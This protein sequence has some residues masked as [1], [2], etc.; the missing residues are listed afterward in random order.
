MDSLDQSNG[1]E[2]TQEGGCEKGKL[3]IVHF[4]TLRSV[5]LSESITGQV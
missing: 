5:S 1:Q 2:G 4:E 3:E